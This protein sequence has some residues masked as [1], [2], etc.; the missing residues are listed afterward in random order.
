MMVRLQ[1]QQRVAVV[2]A[3]ETVTVV[4]PPLTVPAVALVVVVPTTVMVEALVAL[5]ETAQLQQTTPLPVVV[6]RVQTVRLE[7]P[8]ALS[9]LTVAEPTSV[10]KHQ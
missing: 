5:A 4:T 3:V 2:A 6:A 7:V 8:A 9:T 10:Q 1:I